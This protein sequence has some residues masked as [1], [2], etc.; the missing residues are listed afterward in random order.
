MPIFSPILVIVRYSQRLSQARDGQTAGRGP[1]RESYFPCAFTQVLPCGQHGK[2]RGGTVV[3]P[4][5][6]SGRIVNFTQNWLG[7]TYTVEFAPEPG[8][9]LTVIGLTE[10]DI[11]PS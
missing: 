10:G 6:A 3:A 4:S 5:G 8:A 11:Q 2:F 7:T 9:T 1:I